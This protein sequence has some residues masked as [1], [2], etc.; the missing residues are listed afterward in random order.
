MKKLTL[1]TLIFTFA[2]SDNL[3]IYNN[4]LANINTKYNFFV[5][6]GVEKKEFANFPNT[7]ITDSIFVN[8]SKNIKLLEQSFKP[9]RA[10]LSNLL[11]L[12][13][14]QNIKFYPNNSKELLSGVLININP[15]T[16]KVDSNYYILNKASQIIYKIYPKSSNYASIIWKIKANKEANE[17]A[18]INYLANGFNWHTNYIVN[19][20]NNSLDL[21]AF[22][23]ITNKSGKDYLDSNI[24]LI[25]A[26]INRQNAPIRILR[27]TAAAQPMY[28]AKEEAIAPQKLEGYYKYTIPFNV[29]LLNQES[30]QITLI[31]AKDIKFKSYGLAYNNNFSNYG[32][33]KLNFTRHISFLNKKENNL[34]LVLPSGVVRVYKNS[35]YLGEN[36]IQNTPKNEKLDIAIGD[37]FD[38]VGERKI[39]KYISKEKYKFIETTYTLK[40]QGTT[41]LTLKIKENIPR[42]GNTIKYQTTCKDICTKKDESAFIKIYTINLKP[43][44]KYSFKSSFEISY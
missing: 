3:V 20:N 25:A 39:T 36:N 40:N 2:F 18:T 4:N 9:N 8:F 38:A 19:I 23:T 22:A 26:K 42:Y 32:K 35:T 6:S 10:K 1:F 34:G 33:S 14:N 17:S 37:L 5:N 30:K 11:K 16:V 28:D 29:D 44:S 15:I 13:I 21:K 7:I 43:N 41:P 31:D 12:N 27:K 24:S